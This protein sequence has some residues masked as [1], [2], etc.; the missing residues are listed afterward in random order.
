MLHIG[1]QWWEL[2]IYPQ[3]PALQYDS[4]QGQQDQEH[5]QKHHANPNMFHVCKAKGSERKVQGQHVHC[6]S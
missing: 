3:W 5:G 6:T 2:Q 1:G 4:S